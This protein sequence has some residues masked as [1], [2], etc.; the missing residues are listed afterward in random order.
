MPT[1][2][3][4]GGVEGARGCAPT[5]PSI[6]P[7]GPTRSTPAA[8]WATRHLGVD[9]PGCASLST[10]PSGSS[11][12]QWPWSVN[13]SR[14]RSAIT[15]SCVADLGHHV[16][17]GEVE[18]AVAGRSRRSRRRPCSARDA[19][20]HH[21]AEPGRDRLVGGLLQRVA[22]VLHDA[23]HA[24]DRARL[25]GVLAHE[26]RQHQLAGAQRASRRPARR[27]AGVRRSRRGRTSGKPVMR[28]PTGHCVL[29]LAARRP[30]AR[31]EGRVT[32]WPDSSSAARRAAP[33]SASALDELLDRGVRGQHVDPQAVLLG[34]LGRRRADHRDDRRGVRL[35]GDADQ[36]AHRRGRGEHDRVELAGLDR[37][38]HRRGRRGRAHGAVGGDVVDL[39]AEVDQ[40][41]DE[42]LGG[43]VG[44]RQEDPVDRVEQVV[45]RRPVLEQAA[46]P[47]ARRDGHQVGVQAP[48]GAARSAVLSPTAAILRPEKARASRPYSSNFSRTARTAL[49]EV[50]AIH[51]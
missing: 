43:D 45:V 2:A 22:G 31:S 32:G 44:A 11:T 50:K 51:S 20:E 8:A 9:A 34:G 27:R 14:H 40:A 4:S 38:A 21:P 35:A 30:A 1:S 33:K 25:G 23:R 5:W 46:R 39:P 3:C 47:T 28:A 13:S 29:D 15:V 16:G 12:P 37:L 48:V 19:E 6:I 10:Q 17:D 24:R 36:V 18:D 26:Q 49:T 41:R 7:L 42:G